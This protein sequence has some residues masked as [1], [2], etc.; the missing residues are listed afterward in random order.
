MDAEQLATV[1]AGTELDRLIAERVMGWRLL[2]VGGDGDFRWYRFKRNKERVVCPEHPFYPS[3]RFAPSEILTHAWEVVERMRATS[4]FP[5]FELAHRPSGFAC[6]FVDDQHHMLYAETAPLA[7]CRAALL[8]LSAA[9]HAGGG[10][11]TGAG[12]GGAGSRPGFPD[13]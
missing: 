1:P 11:G 7:I 9:A 2:R 10:R 8:A 4:L 3:L 6:N 12:G 13:N 5:W